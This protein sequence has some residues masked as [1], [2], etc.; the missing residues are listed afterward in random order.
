MRSSCTP[1]DHRMDGDITSIRSASHAGSHWPTRERLEDADHVT[2]IVDGSLC[3]AKQATIPITDEGLLRGD[4]AFEVARL[5]AG[6]PF[7]L[8]EHLERLAR[9]AAALRLPYAAAE[10]EREIEHLIAAAGARNAA[11]R[12]VVTRGGMRI[13]IIEALASMPATIALATLEYRPIGVMRGVKS[14]SY[15]PNMLLRRLALEAGSDDALL[16]TPD[17][18]VLEAATA[19]FF[20]VLDDALYT[21]PLAAGILDSITRR[22]LLAVTSACERVTRREELSR[23][24]EA[25]IASTLRE[26]QPVHAIDGHGL[27]SAPGKRTSEAAELLQARI[28]SLI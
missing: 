12:V 13:G 1:M 27:A 20:Y 26:V 2:A 7:A 11:L 28:Q 9:S 16:A 6:R 3:P 18:E 22:H 19:A 15:A 4:G 25:F 21:P 5:Y 24:Q 17:G 14:L 8:D 10:L 23:L